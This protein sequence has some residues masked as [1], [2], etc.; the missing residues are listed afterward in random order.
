MPPTHC[1][2]EPVTRRQ[3]RRRLDA[4]GRRAGRAIVVLWLAVLPRIADLPPVQ[5]HIDFLEQRQIDP[6]AMFYTELEGMGEVRARM[7]RIRRDHP[8]VFWEPH[9]GQVSRPGDR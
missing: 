2:S 6:S 5:A 4:A 3:P 7:A 1:R 9:L 8:A